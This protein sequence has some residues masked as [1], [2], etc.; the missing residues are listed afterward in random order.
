LY[1]H[2]LFTRQG[3]VLK[4]DSPTASG[5]VVDFEVSL[6]GSPVFALEATAHFGSQLQQDKHHEA[7]LLLQSI[8]PHLS[9]LLRGVSLCVNDIVQG[10]QTASGRKMAAAIAERVADWRQS[11][12]SE[13][14]IEWQS[15]RS[16]GKWR[17]RVVDPRSAWEIEFEPLALRDPMESFDDPFGMISTGRFEFEDTNTIQREVRKK[18]GQHRG[19]DLP[20]VVAVTSHDALC[21]MSD[22]FA[23]LMLVGETRLLKNPPPHVRNGLWGDSKRSAI[24]KCPAVLLCHACLPWALG[25]VGPTLWSNPSR[26]LPALVEQWR[27]KS[28][29]WDVASGAIV[30]DNGIH[31]A[32]VLGLETQTPTYPDSIWG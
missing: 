29:T 32:I 30:R 2:E 11:L 31:S 9:P 6:Q 17:M 24:S 18:I 3:F 7:H 12:D 15:G 8:R 16:Y 5:S 14:T 27:C 21:S 10:T 1:L 13:S 19:L 25:R 28:R 23:S 22:E 26:P 4:A 20:L